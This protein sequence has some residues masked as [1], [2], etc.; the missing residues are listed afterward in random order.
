MLKS[1]EYAAI[2]ADYDRI[3]RDHFPKSYFHPDGMRFANS[4]ALFPPAALA[5]AIAAE[6][7]TQCRMLCYGAFPSWD[8]VQARLLELRPLL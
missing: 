3:S 8:A 4:D 1:D 7:Q 5:T 2:K 6:Y